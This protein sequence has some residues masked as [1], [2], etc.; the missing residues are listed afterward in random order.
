V[1]EIARLYTRDRNDIERM[2]RAAAPDVLPESWRDWFRKRI[3]GRA[4]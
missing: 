3:D 2:R 4:A 1:T